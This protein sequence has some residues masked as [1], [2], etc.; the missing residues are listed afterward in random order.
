MPEKD[1]QGVHL[2]VLLNIGGLIKARFLACQYEL[3]NRFVRTLTLLVVEGSK[4]SELNSRKRSPMQGT[5]QV[6]QLVLVE[7]VL[8]PTNAELTDLLERAAKSD[9]AALVLHSKTVITFPSSFIQQ[10]ET[11]GLPVFDLPSDVSLYE[12]ISPLV[13]ELLRREHALFNQI[14]SVQERMVSQI[15][16]GQGGQGIV[17]LLFTFI[18]VPV[19]LIDNVGT[20]L[21]SAGNWHRIPNADILSTS[22]QLISALESLADRDR[23]RYSPEGTF[24][25]LAF[26]Q[27]GLFARPVI[28][29]K[30]VVGWLILISK[31]KATNI[32]NRIA[33]DQAALAAAIEID[34]QEAVRQVEGRMQSNLLENLF[35]PNKV[36]GSLEEHAQR[37]GWDL[38]Q[39]RSVIL[40]SWDEEE[41][42]TQL[43]RKVEAVVT[44]Y[45]LA[46]RPESLV[47]M[48]DREILIL[49]HLPEASDASAA[50]EILQDLA[51]GM[52]K[53]WSLHLKK[54]SIVVA[55][56]GVQPS[57]KGIVTSY[58]E[59]RRALALRRRLGLRS[60][61]V[62]FEDVRIFSL[63]ENHLDDEA[64]GALFQ[65]TVGPLVEYDTKHKTELVR[66]AEIYFD[67]NCHLQQAADQLF[68]HPS[69]LKYRL[70]RIR[71]I[72]G[73]DPFYGK[74]HLDY[75]LATKIA[76]LL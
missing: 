10:A 19:L 57:L 26:G 43:L 52:F 37:L 61:I 16:A 25:L 36:T 68:I 51:Q 3:E 50:T 67:C 70:Q 48:R 8:P 14:T 27:N 17:D 12:I 40:V 59:A 55:I 39:K 65:R 22:D 47:L 15:L 29:G 6:D 21:G 42:N 32:I 60:P 28:A 63:L 56:G 62:T 30:E 46:W 1:K 9:C 34:R 44:R 66:T 75:Y 4:S 35:I 73:S 2:N 45:I 13:D 31:P 71:D 69:S 54:I 41:I 49:P 58:N 76:R 38:R 53:E 5:L 33:L 64:A 20:I 24:D 18:D 23:Q 11:L 7:F 72:L 74:D